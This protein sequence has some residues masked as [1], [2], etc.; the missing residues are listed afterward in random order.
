MEFK[1]NEATVDLSYVNYKIFDKASILLFIY[2]YN[3]SINYQRIYNR[4]D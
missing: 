2:K 1:F 3:Q 4:N